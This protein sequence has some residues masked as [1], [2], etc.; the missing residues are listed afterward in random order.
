MVAVAPDDLWAFGRTGTDRNGRPYALRG[1]GEHWTPSPLPEQ[2]KG[3]VLDAA[4]SGPADVWLITGSTRNPTV[5]RGDGK[6]W[7]AQDGLPYGTRIEA[8]DAT[9]A[10]AYWPGAVD[11]IWFHDGAAWRPTALP[12]GVAL[13]AFDATSPGDLWAVGSTPTGVF[14]SDGSRWTQ[15]RHLDWAA[16]VLVAAAPDDVWIMGNRIPPPVEEREV[17]PLTVP[18]AAHWDG[19]SWRQIDLPQQ[20]RPLRAVADGRGGVRVLVAPNPPD[21]DAVAP[22]TAILS[23]SATGTEEVSAPMI[24]GGRVSLNGLAVVGDTVWAVGAAYPASVTLS[25][26]TSVVYTRQSRRS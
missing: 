6:S 3:G 17:E 16:N 19:H 2:A 12:D 5:F 24:F 8:L 7:A 23:L 20:W 21:D 10:W 9:H 4:A 11:Q 26:S 15:V 1:D 13:Q 25:A 14:R 18:L 22:T